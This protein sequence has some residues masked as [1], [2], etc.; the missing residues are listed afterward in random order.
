MLDL[1]TILFVVVFIAM[2]QSVIWLFVWLTWRRFYELRLMAAA[3]TCFAIGVLLFVARGAEPAA[4]QIVGAN[5]IVKLGVVLMADGLARF[6]GQPRY[7]WL[8]MSLLAFQ[9]V[10]WSL[11]VTLD[12][13]NLA[14]R[15]N[16][17]TLFTLAMMGFMSLTLARDRSQPRLLRWSMIAAMAVH[18][19]ASLALSLFETFDPSPAAMPAVLSDRHVW[20][21]F[22]SLLFLIAFFA[23]MLFMV[24]ARL[25]ADLHARNEALTAEIVRRRRLEAELSDSLETEKRLREEQRQFMRMIGHEF[26]T[27]LATIQLGSEMIG[28]ILEESAAAVSRPLAGIAESVRRMAGLID[29]F[30]A[31]ERQDGAVLQ[32]EPIRVAE[33]VAEVERH[34]AAL[35]HG[36]RLHFTVAS[37]GGRYW[38][39]SGMLQTV[40][41][42]LIDNALKYSP[43]DRPVEVSAVVR[44]GAVEVSVLDRGIGI[45]EAEREAVGRR[46]FRAS[47]AAAA[48]GT[49]IGLYNSRRLLDY[50]GGTLELRAG[51]PEGTVVS[52]RL[53]M[54]GPRPEAAAAAEGPAD[55]GA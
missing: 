10:A 7:P 50:H 6:L 39:D 34:F 18:M 48:T 4:W 14:L 35:G 45:P 24:S 3:S 54:P 9:V 31:A 33:L 2:M 46:F 29:R 44:E 8:G 40:L 36:E 41:I 28:M 22:E 16:A 26:R 27:P 1:K 42:N 55:R 51:E 30:L 17:S 20:Y 52:V 49:G 37:G 21:F 43:E 23:C 19:S 15:V 25:S 38:G 11:A 53:P 13:Q 32:V 12:P 47:N 5:T